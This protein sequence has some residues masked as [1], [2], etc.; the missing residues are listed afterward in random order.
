MA[1][2]TRKGA[3]HKKTI[4][5]KKT[6]K[7]GNFAPILSFTIPRGVQKSLHTLAT[8]AGMAFNEKFVV[9]TLTQISKIAGV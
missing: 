5:A 8:N 7:G 2:S 6:N 1:R 9:K 3:T 4:A